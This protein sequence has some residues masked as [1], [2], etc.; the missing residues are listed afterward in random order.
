MLQLSN[1]DFRYP[2]GEFHLSIPELAVEVGEKVG[3]VGPSGSGKTT[4]LNLVAGI[5]TP[6][7]GEVSVEDG[8]N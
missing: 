2:E 4:L 1:I 6:Q 7:T 8:H 5:L 3:V